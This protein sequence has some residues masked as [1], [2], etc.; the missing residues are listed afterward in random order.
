MPLLK[1]TQCEEKDHEPLYG[2]NNDQRKMFV[3]EI[4]QFSQKWKTLES[5]H[6]YQTTNSTYTGWSSQCTN[7]YGLGL[8][9]HTQSSATF[10]T[11]SVAG[12]D[13]V[14]N[15]VQSSREFL[16]NDGSEQCENFGNMTQIADDSDII[17]KM[18]IEI[19]D[20]WP[21]DLD[22]SFKIK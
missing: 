16:S 5:L 18:E 1:G 12:G 19:P 14:T 13:S 21:F 4:Q 11:S 6:Q 20:Q 3:L 9:T 10:S 2:M 22:G 8:S 17:Y 7:S 15:S